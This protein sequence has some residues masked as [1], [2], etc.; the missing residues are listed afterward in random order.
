MMSCFF[1]WLDKNKEKDSIIIQICKIIYTI[2]IKTVP[3]IIFTT[4]M[5][6]IIPILWGEVRRFSIVLLILLVLQNIA[7]WICDRYHVR[8]FE[9]RKFAASILADQSALL[10]SMTIMIHDTSTWKTEIFKK[11]CDM[12]CARLHEEFKNVYKCNVRVSIEYTFEKEFNGVKKLC[13]KMAGRCS[14]DRSQTKK[15]TKLSNRN[16][17]FSYKIF[18]E[19]LIGIHYLKENDL[20]DKTKWYKNPNHSIEVIQYIALASSF[21]DKDVSFVLQ[22]DCLEPFTF[23]EKDTYEE[24]KKFANVYLKPYVNMISLAYLLGRNKKGLIGEV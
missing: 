7:F 10:N 11:T 17:Y 12:V 9:E 3:H 13:R 2:E 14:G 22:V 23:G 4:I 19:N 8:V 1:D 24:M 21:N 20:K 6:I 5:G 15:A 18:K 16:K